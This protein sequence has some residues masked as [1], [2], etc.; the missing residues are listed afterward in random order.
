MMHS[1]TQPHCP[2]LHIYTLLTPLETF[3]PMFSPRS[4]DELKRA[5][6]GVCSEG[7]R[8]K[9]MLHGHIGKWDVSHVTDMSKIFYDMHTF[10]Q[11]LSKWDV[12]RVVDMRGMFWNAHAFNQDLSKWDVSR[13]TDMHAM[14]ASAQAFNQH[15]YKWDVSRVADMDWMFCQANSFQ[16]TLCGAAWV[17]SNASKIHM[18]EGSPGSISKT[19]CGAYDILLVHSYCFHFS[20]PYGHIVA[21]KCPHAHALIHVHSH[22]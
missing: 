10:N 12:S 20:P 11:D 9:A 19:V 7:N 5:I 2:H 8:Q 15:L 14:F 17:N 6:V 1:S 21:S 13:V 18:F 16:Q 4:R 3:L 22:H